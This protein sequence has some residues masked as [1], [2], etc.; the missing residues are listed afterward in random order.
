MCFLNSVRLV[1]SSVFGSVS[2]KELVS[3]GNADVCPPSS[4]L[5]D[6]DFLSGSRNGELMPLPLL[7]LRDKK[8]VMRPG[9]IAWAAGEKRCGRR[10]ELN[11]DD[12]LGVDGALVGGSASLLSSGSSSVLTSRRIGKLRKSEAEES[13][14][15][16]RETPCSRSEKELERLLENDSPPE[17]RFL[18]AR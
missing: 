12:R 13:K 7:G 15:A 2:L 5:I 6:P 4:D 18:A 14:L 3:S 8:R 16:V 17:I 10:T 11:P 9:V 1:V